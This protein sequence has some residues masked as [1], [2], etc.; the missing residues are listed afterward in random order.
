MLA[1]DY[2][3]IA[4]DLLLIN[5]QIIYFKNPK[6]LNLPLN[7]L[8]KNKNFNYNSSTEIDIWK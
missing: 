1:Y 5:S 6:A 2:E 4:G 8:W 3:S 7:N